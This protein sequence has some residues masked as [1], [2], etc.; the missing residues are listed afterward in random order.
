MAPMYRTRLRDMRARLLGEPFGRR[1]MC[2]RGRGSRPRLRDIRLRLPDT[3]L[4]WRGIPVRWRRIRTGLA[5]GAATVALAVLCA[6]AAQ[7][8]NQASGT[9]DPGACTFG[10][11]PYSGRPWP[12]QRVLLDEV[13]EQARGRD[14]RV[15]V[16]DTGVDNRHPQLRDAVD[17][18]L[19]HNFLPRDAGL[20][21]AQLGAAN[22]TTDTVGHGTKV[23]GIIAA[24][25]DPATGFVG[26]APAATIIPIDQNDAEGNG[27]PE[28]LAQAVQHAV[29][30]GADIIN[31]S[32]DTAKSIR[33]SRQ[34]ETEVAEALAAGRIVIASAG[35]N[36]ADG[37]TRPTYPA[38]YPGVLAVAASDRDNERAYFS[39][40]GTFVGIA[41]PGTDIVSTVPGSGHCADSGTS[42]SAPYVAG[43]AALLKEKHADWS[44]EEIVHH[45]QRTAERAAPGRDPQVGW[46]VADPLR[47]LTDDTRPP[48]GPVTEESRAGRPDG[49]AP[50]ASRAR[51][52]E[53]AQQRDVRRA[54]YVLVGSAVAV[55][56]LTGSAVAA[57]DARRRRGWRG[58]DSGGRRGADVEGRLGA[59]AEG[60]CGADAGGRPMPMPPAERVSEA[61]PPIAG[62]PGNHR[63]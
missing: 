44:G 16:I 11:K 53:T 48:P 32:Q 30:K 59:D 36:G 60:Q 8:R 52:G 7:A 27:T 29:D 18:R 38:S 40:S 22:G 42:F 63:L 3:L 33:P 35:N 61:R 21:P 13:W 39:Q 28:L 6:P 14:V 47:A 58:A 43:I 5:R 12:L 34:L 23:A 26:L 46:G 15:A 62:T 9:A 41:A 50:D 19:G 17:V 4:R 37:N 49:D 54:T 25:P 24:R 55:A 2:T 51:W 57:R 56:V 10:S 31:I 20:S 45:I 1:Y